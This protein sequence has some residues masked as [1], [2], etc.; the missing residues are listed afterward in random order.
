MSRTDK[1]QPYRVRLWDGTLQRVAV[2]DHRDGIC[3]LPATLEEDL[4][5]HDRHRSH[6]TS[7]YWDLHWTGVTVCACALCSGRP[8]A[9][10]ERRADRHRAKRELVE[11]VKLARRDWRNV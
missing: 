4:A 7:C 6:G 3:D 1:T 11:L 2:H 10:A 9:R 5:W 8:W